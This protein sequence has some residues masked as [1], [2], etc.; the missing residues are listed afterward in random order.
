VSFLRPHLRIPTLALSNV[1]RSFLTGRPCLDA[2]TGRRA[3]LLF[4]SEQGRCVL[5]GYQIFDAHRLLGIAEEQLLEFIIV[6]DGPGQLG[7]DL[8]P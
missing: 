1:R 7:M 2:A 4:S 5:L 6:P 3:N 8:A